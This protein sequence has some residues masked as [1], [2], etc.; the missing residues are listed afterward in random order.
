M[1]EGDLVLTPAWTWHEH[2]HAGTGRM[3]W[4]DALDVPLQRFFNTIAFEPGPAK[5]LPPL[6]ADAEFAAAG[7]VPAAAAAAAN[8]SY[9]PM[10]RYGW[11]EARAA[12]AKMAPEADGAR[13]L[14][15]VNP[16]TGGPVMSLIDCYLLDL[17]AERDTRQHWSTAGTMCV[18]AEG[19]GTT[20]IGE[21]TLSWR[22][23]DIFSLPGKTWHS[24]RAGAP[25]AKLFLA[26]DRE[27]LAR[28]GLLEERTR[29]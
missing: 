27:I 12:I 13:R 19:V 22:R 26:T 9:S 10:F 21:Q 15:Y 17:P 14:R 1:Q 8:P 5:D 20:H 7:M 29:D 25:G 16:V 11:H 4:F 6:G 23:N 3:V 28:L 24:H 18:V 2:V